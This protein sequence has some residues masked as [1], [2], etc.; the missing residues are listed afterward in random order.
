[1]FE[2]FRSKPHN[3]AYDNGKYLDQ[4]LQQYVTIENELKD[5]IQDQYDRQGDMRRGLRDLLERGPKQLEELRHFQQTPDTYAADYRDSLKDAMDDMSDA[6][7]GATQA[8]ADQVKKFG[9]LKQQ[10]KEDARAAKEREKE[11]H[12]RA[13]EEKKLQKKERKQGPPSDEEDN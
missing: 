12:K 11:A 2:D 1:L 6:L 5:W 8:L 9:E 7:D 3:S 13:K 4:A 10:E